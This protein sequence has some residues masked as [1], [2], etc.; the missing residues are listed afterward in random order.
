M[1]LREVSFLNRNWIELAQ[2][3]VHWQS[4]L[5]VVFNFWVPSEKESVSQPA[6]QS[7]DWLVD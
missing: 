3:S 6:S 1:D 7:G 5:L 4:F 2:D